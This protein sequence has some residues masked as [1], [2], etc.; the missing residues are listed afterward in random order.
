MS[1]IYV[2][3]RISTPKQNIERQVRN[4]LKEYPDRI[5][6]QETFIE[7]K[8]QVRIELEKLI[9]NI[10]IGDTIVFDCVSRISRNA[11]KGFTLYEKLYHK[12]VDLVFLKEPQINM[13]TYRRT[14]QEKR[15]LLLHSGDEATDRLV[16]SII[17]ALNDYI[18]TLG[19]DK[20]SSLSGSPRKRLR[21]FINEHERASRQCYGTVSR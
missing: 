1:R 20:S 17:D 7:T 8:Y 15:T 2:Y 21:I 9:R 10:R 16:R 14:L 5:I 4:I 19:A 18:M 3:C 12:G 11:E 13:D 6:V